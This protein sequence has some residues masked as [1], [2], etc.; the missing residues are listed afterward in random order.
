MRHVATDLTAPSGAGLVQ[1]NSPLPYMFGGLLLVFGVI[2]VALM[3]LACC[4]DK[5]SITGPSSGDQKDEKSA[6]AIDP[7]AALEPKIVVIMAGDD[8]P[9]RIARPSASTS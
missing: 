5:P 6:E 9:T 7:P 1:W 8:H 3:F 4:H 2:A